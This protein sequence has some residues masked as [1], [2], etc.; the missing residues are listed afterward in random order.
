MVSCSYTLAILHINAAPKVMSFIML[1]NNIRG[2]CWWYG[3][4]G[5]TFQYSLKFV[6]MW[7]MAAEGQSGKTASDVEVCMKQRCVT[8]FYHVKKWHLLT[9]TSICWRFME[10]K[11][12]MWVWWG[13]GWCVS[14]VATAGHLHW[15][16][17]F[18]S[19]ACRLLFITSK[20]A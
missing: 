18:T 9:F 2:G 5:W 1:A 4:R 19:T 13:G 16:K 8:E 11:Q 3:S 10:P 20:N 7:Q 12:W 14:A 17:F 15:C 6:A